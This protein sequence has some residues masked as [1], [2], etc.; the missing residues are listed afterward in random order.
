MASKRK[1]PCGCSRSAHGS[2]DKD[3]SNCRE[4]RRR[5]RERSKKQARAR[6]PKG[7]MEARFVGQLNW[8]GRPRA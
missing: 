7:P 4:V 2:K 3:V 8:P 6:E 1:L 5:Q